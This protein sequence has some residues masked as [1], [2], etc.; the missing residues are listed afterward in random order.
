MIL[1]VDRNIQD[2]NKKGQYNFFYFRRSLGNITQFKRV[3]FE[4]SFIDEVKANKD[5]TTNS[6]KIFFLSAEE[7]QTLIILT[8]REFKRD[9]RVSSILK[10]AKPLTLFLTQDS[11]VK[12]DYHTNKFMHDNDIMGVSQQLFK[13]L[14]YSKD[15]TKEALFI[16]KAYQTPPKNSVVLNV[17][18]YLT[19]ATNDL[20]SIFKSANIIKNPSI[21][22]YLR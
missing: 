21:S 9:K 19:E 11:I 14:H 20:L 7:I 10:G 15:I 18:R 16:L 6:K 1:V 8:D 4:N 2:V 22:L 13:K 12:I 3:Y 5:Y 17:N